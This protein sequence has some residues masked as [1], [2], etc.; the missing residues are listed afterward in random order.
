MAEGG[1]AGR[2]A[3]HRSRLTASLVLLVYAAVGIVALFPVTPGG[4]GIVEAS[5]SGLLILAGIRPGYAVR[6]A[7]WPARGRGQPLRLSA[8]AAR[9]WRSCAGLMV[10]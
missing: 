7:G 3:R 2:P 6:E 8:L 9:G 10:R 4:L 1:P 5:L